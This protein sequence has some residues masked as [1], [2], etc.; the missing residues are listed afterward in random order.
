MLEIVTL[1]LSLSE[2]IRLTVVQY[3]SMLTDLFGD[4]STRHLLQAPGASLPGASPPITDAAVF[5]PDDR[6]AAVPA[7]TPDAAVAP[8]AAVVADTLDHVAEHDHPSTS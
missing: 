1:V 2:E 8:V 4:P 6:D 7:S 3:S 5:A